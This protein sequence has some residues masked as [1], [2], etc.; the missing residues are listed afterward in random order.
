MDLVRRA[1]RLLCTPVV[2]SAI[3]A[4]TATSAF[5]KDVVRLPV[6]YMNQ[7]DGNTCLPTSLLMAMHFLGRAD[8]TTETVYTLH[9]TCR[10]DRYNVPTLVRQFGLYAFPSW[11]EHAWTRETVEAELRSGRPVVLGLDCSRAGHFVLAVG[12]TDD[13]QVIL[14]D[15]YWKE[16]G[17]QFGGPFYTTPW[18][19]LIWRNGIMIRPDPFPD[20]PRAISGSLVQTTAPR[21]LVRGELTMAEFAIKNNGREPW[22]DGVCL[23]AVDA[24][25]S[26]A[27]ERESRFAVLPGSDSTTTATWISASRAA[28]PDK[29]NLVPGE[30]AYFQVPLR[31]PS[32]FPDENSVV[33]RENFNLVDGEGR[34]F[35]EH[36][37]TGPSNRQVFFRVAVVAPA[38]KLNAPLVETAAGGKPALPWKLKFASAEGVALAAGS[39]DAPAAEDSQSSTAL[40]IADIATS[41]GGPA[42]RVKAPVGDEDFQMAYVG[43]PRASDYRV[44][45]WIYCDFDPENKK[46]GYNRFGVF[47]RD[48]G[49]H[50]ISPKTETENGECIFMGFDSDDG[51]IR[52]GNFANGGI[53]DMVRE[54]THIKESG[55]HKFGISAKGT[56]VTFELDGK[57]VGTGSIR[58]GRGWDED[59]QGAFQAGDCGVLVRS[60]FPPDS[61]RRRDLLFAGFRAEPL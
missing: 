21:T 37:Q 51:R 61:D 57:V 40:E 19:P 60:L 11:L 31:A 18:E 36:W 30:I 55:W 29:K 9:K 48:S 14:H 52:M 7:P 53:G 13:G 1:L 49:H 4:T 44:E 39:G 42:L 58:G 46:S 16:T 35:S 47:L 32:D 10:Y 12:Y 54:R 45:S 26:P 34:L 41:A 8:L 43:D 50:R 33:F 25:T 17:W 27:R 22:P 38:P 3:F 24:Y 15:P 2:L 28:Y 23:A 6:P 56:T 20:A 5:A 59:F